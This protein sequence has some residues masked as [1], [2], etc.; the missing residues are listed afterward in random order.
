MNDIKRTQ[1]QQQQQQKIYTY[2]YINKWKKKEASNQPLMTAYKNQ[3][4]PTA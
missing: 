4:Q 2:I 1:Q 3:N